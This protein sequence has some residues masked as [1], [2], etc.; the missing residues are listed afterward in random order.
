MPQDGAEGATVGG[1]G[2]LARPAHLGKDRR[3][4]ADLVAA[5]A[6]LFGGGPAKDPL[7]LAEGSAEAREFAAR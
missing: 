4:D 6:Q 1:G 2:R 7:R 5:A 3:G